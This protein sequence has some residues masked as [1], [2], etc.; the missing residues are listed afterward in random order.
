[1]RARSAFST[2]PCSSHAASWQISVV[3][4][5]D[6]DHVVVEHAGVDRVRILLREER[7]RRVEAMAARDCGGRLARLP[8]RPFPRRGRARVVRGASEDEELDAGLAGLRH[9][10]DVIGG[11]FV[12][13]LRCRRQRIVH[14]EVFRVGEDRPQHARRRGGFDRAME[15]ATSRLAGVKWTRPSV[16]SI[17]GLTVA[18]FAAHIAAA[19]EH[20]ARSCGAS[21]RALATIS[22]SVPAKPSAR[23]APHVGPLVGR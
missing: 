13:E 7:A 4:I 3:A 14:D 17:D 11:A 9:E 5:A 12:A 6:G 22:A 1:M 8:R 18:A 23:S 19:D 10:P 16:V 20:A 2:V 21:L 15:V